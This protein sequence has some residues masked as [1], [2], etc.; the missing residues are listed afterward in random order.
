MEVVTDIGELLIVQVLVGLPQQKLIVGVATTGVLSAPVLALVR[1]AKTEVA[2]WI[3]NIPLQGRSEE[4]EFN[5]VLYKPYLIPL[6]LTIVAGVGQTEDP[7][8]RGYP[9]E[10]V[11]AGMV[12]QPTGLTEAEVLIMYSHQVV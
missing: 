4:E 5:Q 1:Q 9:L 11:V 7:E 12:A 2:T 8:L 6:P 3:T 10:V